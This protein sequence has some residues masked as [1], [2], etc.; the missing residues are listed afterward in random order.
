MRYIDPTSN[1]VIGERNI[2]SGKLP[3]IKEVGRQFPCGTSLSVFLPTLT[4]QLLKMLAR[5]Q[6][7]SIIS[8]FT[9]VYDWSN[10][11]PDF[12]NIIPVTQKVIL[13]LDLLALL[14]LTTLFLNFLWRDIRFG[15][16][17]LL[18]MI[19]E[20]SLSLYLI[21]ASMFFVIY[22]LVD[23][24]IS[25]F[26]SFLHGAWQLINWEIWSLKTSNL[27]LASKSLLKMLAQSRSEKLL[28]NFFSSNLE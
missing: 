20:Y 3:F 14:S 16:V 8:N 26:E 11:R 27:L 25:C 10:S 7:L 19:R 22:G 1:E 4:K 6:G 2:D 18:F 24:F 13:E 5:A 21:L 23:N 15:S 28:T 17:Y 9:N 12:L